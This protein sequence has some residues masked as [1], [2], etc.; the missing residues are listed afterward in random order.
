MSI[1]TYIELKAAVES[2]LDHTLFTARVPEFIA[3]FE[4]AA[5]RRLRVQQQETQGAAL[6]PSAVNGSVLQN[7]SPEHDRDQ[8]RLLPEDSRAHGRGRDELAARRAS[9]SLSLRRSGRGR[10][11][12]GERRTRAALEGAA[13]RNLR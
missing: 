13:R 5:N 7:P 8:A 1:T 10:N 6:T 3:L 9:R 11:V 12:R 2:W 4:A